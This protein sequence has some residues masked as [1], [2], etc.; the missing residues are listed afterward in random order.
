AQGDETTLNTV[1]QLA[2]NQEGII[3]GNYFD[4]LM[5]SSSIVHGAVDKKTEQAAWTIG[6]KKEPVF[7][8][9]IYNLTKDETPVLV[10]FGPDKPLQGLRVPMEQKNDQ[11]S[12]GT[13][14][15]ANQ[16]P[17]NGQATAQVTVEV[18]AGAQVFFDGSPTTQ[19]GT[20]RVYVTP[21]LPFGQEFS[22]N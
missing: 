14:P 22:Y 15:G 4:A 7:E 12:P 3:R 11:P 1:L 17:A 21:P 2:V 13:A 20:Q 19:T 5:N 9:G 16:G 8:A 18:P 6:D 10:H